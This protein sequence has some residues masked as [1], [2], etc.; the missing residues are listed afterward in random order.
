MPRQ[1]DRGTVRWQAGI[2]FA[3]AGFCPTNEDAAG[4]R[5]S[6]E[7]LRMLII[8]NEI[9]AHVLTRAHTIEVR[10]QS[11][12]ALVTARDAVCRPRIDIQIPTDEP[13]VIYQWG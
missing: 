12:T 9:V 11:Y 6:H 5:D 13:G 3:P 8:N 2:A 1:H 10:E 7:S 4:C